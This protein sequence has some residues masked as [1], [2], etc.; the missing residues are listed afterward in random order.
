VNGDAA[1]ENSMSEAGFSNG[2]RDARGPAVPDGAAVRSGLRELLRRYEGGLSSAVERLQSLLQELASHENLSPLTIAIFGIACLTIAGGVWVAACTASGY[3]TGLTL[4]AGACLA[5]RWIWKA[6]GNE[7]SWLRYDSAEP[8][9]SRTG[10]PGREPVS[11]R[12]VKGNTTLFKYSDGSVVYEHKRDTNA[13]CE[14]ERVKNDDLKAAVRTT[15]L[16]DGTKVREFPDGLRTL[17]KRFSDASYLMKWQGHSEFDSIELRTDDGT[18]LEIYSNGHKIVDCADGSCYEDDP[19]GHRRV[20]N[21]CYGVERVDILPEHEIVRNI[22]L[23]HLMN[24]VLIGGDVE[25]FCPPSLTSALT[26]ML[27]RIEQPTEPAS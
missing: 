4:G 10:A 1:G 18:F 14:M 11:C 13:N 15:Y 23:F 3:L 20:F 26:G 21:S 25:R 8:L 22:Q 7:V 6:Q 9:S 19:D 24:V 2:S 16:S 17:S 12:V 27:A 5:A